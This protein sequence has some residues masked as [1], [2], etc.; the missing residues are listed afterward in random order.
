MK[1]IKILS[2]EEI[3]NY[4]KIFH[5]PI[6][7][8]R[9][10]AAIYDNLQDFKKNLYELD[11]EYASID[12]EPDEDDDD[13]DDDFEE[14]EESLNHKL[15]SMLPYFKEV[16]AKE[17]GLNIDS[18][19][20]EDM[21]VIKINK[22]LYNHI[23]PFTKEQKKKINCANCPL[24][25]KNFIP[26]SFEA[27]HDEKIPIEEAVEMIKFNAYHFTEETF[28]KIMEIQNNKNSLN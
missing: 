16:I 20:E 26:I 17:T 1:L 10:M 18:I 21:Q 5:Q 2:S 25:I 7:V 12:D 19:K 15:E 4:S 28:N 3:A 11:E 9:N 23:C 24:H 8:V 13:N 6:S 27:A 14:D 22:N